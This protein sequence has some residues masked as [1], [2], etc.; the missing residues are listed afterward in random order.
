MP[1][2]HTTTS[3]T[4]STRWLALAAT[5]AAMNAIGC[6]TADEERAPAPGSESAADVLDE[7]SA[8]D[9]EEQGVTCGGKVC[10]SGTVCC[11]PFCGTCTPK[12]MECT[13]GCGG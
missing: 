6:A 12:G 8:A 13:L 9:V 3:T 5:F 10:P 11:D 4:S 7:A 1:M 2:K